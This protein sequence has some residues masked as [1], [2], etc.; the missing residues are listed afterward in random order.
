MFSSLPFKFV[1][2][3]QPFYVHAELLSQRSKPLAAMMQ[4]DMV[5]KSQGFAEL[6]D[7]DQ[8]TFVRFLQWLYQ[9]Y[10]H[11]ALPIPT[12]TLANPTTK[13]GDQSLDHTIGA[14]LGFSAP[15][16]IPGS[17][18][19]STLTTGNPIT[20]EEDFLWLMSSRR[21]PNKKRK[22]SQ[23]TSGDAAF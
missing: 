14:P 1:N 7:V 9:G 19:Q 16:A 23:N 2:G 18:N 13:P 11:A 22:A 4:S 10:Y 6:E 17:N 3:G 8:A 12:P 15:P 21:G 5:E 20:N